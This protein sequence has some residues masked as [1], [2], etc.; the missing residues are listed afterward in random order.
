MSHKQPGSSENR[1]VSQ[2]VSMKAAAIIQFGSKYA[3]ILVQLVIT[4]VLARLLTPA[5][6][7]Q[8]AI[9][10]VFTSFFS[11]FSDMG[12]SNAIIQYRQLDTRDFEKLFTFSVI[13]ALGLT[14]PFCALA[15][16]LSAFYADMGL[17]P[18]FLASSPT[19]LF[20]TLNMVPNGIMLREK[21]FRSIGVRLIVTTAV[22]G[23][24]TVVLA[25]VGWG[26]YAL[27]LQTVLQALLVLVWNLVSSPLR[28]LDIH[29]MAPLKLIFAYTSFQMGFN[30]VNYFARN[31][32]NLLVGRV[33]GDTP[34]G[35]YDKAYKLTTYPL[36][37]F[38][39]VIAGI[40]QPYMAEHQK[41]PE[42]IWDFWR[43]ITKLISLVGA[44]I[45]AAMVACSREVVLL[46]YGSQWIASVPLFAALAVSI[47]PQL[48]ESTTGAFYQS[49][50]RTD[51]LFRFGVI[52]TCCTVAL[53]VA[54][55]V[56]GDLQMVACC[57]AAA[58]V[59]KTFITFW[60]LVTKGFSKRYREVLFLAPEIVIGIV[61]AVAAMGLGLLLPDNLW[62]Q[63]LA[64]GFL[65]L[66]ICAVGYRCTHQLHWLD[67]LRP[68]R[69]SA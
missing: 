1:S 60:G 51:L 24:V 44:F 35:Y 28:R 3:T 18:L 39:G 57:V 50:G 58:F 56:T 61:A 27:V 63:L 43:R 22:S 17:V 31:L 69:R 9:V 11:L 30:T 19:L 64:K 36:G 33:F 15:W 42:V 47:Y 68:A 20:N 37:V 12:V 46:F 8:V 67:M 66:G 38:S 41:E 10:T 16:P 55:L 54:G 32:D 25:L 40:V 53:L 23:A 26:A 65:V 6:F 13:L 21:R 7:G 62:V 4:A 5:D 14:G 49:I 52:N 48:L 2:P 29:F 34:L 45:A 59:L